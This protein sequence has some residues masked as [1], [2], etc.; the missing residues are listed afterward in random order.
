MTNV[1]VSGNAVGVGGAGGTGVNGGGIGPNGNAGIGGGI[2]VVDWSVAL[3]HTVVAGNTAPLGSSPDI[4]GDVAAA[5]SYNL[6][7]DGSDTTGIS[8]GPNGNRLGT[9]ASPINPLLGPLADNGGPTLTRAPQAASP[10]ID[11]G[12]TTCPTPPLGSGP[13][14]ADQRGVGRP[15]GAKCDI[16]AVEVVQTTGTLPS[17][18][19][20]GSPSGSSPVPLPRPQSTVPR[21]AH[22]VR[23]QRGGRSAT[24]HDGVGCEGYT[25]P[26]A[27]WP[28]R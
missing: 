15:Q 5:S 2:Y 19:P 20:P 7:G 25:T 9:S 24:I 21:V 1:T 10:L 3:R 8:D 26:C 16:G 23:C 11:G 27:A 12:N 22:Q 28:R 18:K 14:A 4:R 6:I 17:P 13:L